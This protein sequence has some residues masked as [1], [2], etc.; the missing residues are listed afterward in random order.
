MDTEEDAP[1]GG[2]GDEL[3]VAALFG[4]PALSGLRV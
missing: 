2:D 1:P 4:E 3:R